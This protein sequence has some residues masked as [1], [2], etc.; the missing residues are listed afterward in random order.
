VVVSDVVFSDT[1]RAD[2]QQRITRLTRSGCAV[3]WLALD[4]AAPLDGSHP[5]LLDDPADAAATIGRAAARALPRRLMGCLTPA[6]SEAANM[7]TTPD[8]VR[9]FQEAGVPFAPGKAANAGGVATSGLEMAQNAGRESWTFEKAEAELTRIMK[10][11]H[12]DCHETAERYG[13]PG[14]YVM[15]ANIAAFERISDAILAQGL[16]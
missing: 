15:G 1:E 2:G 16:I 13:A 7:P 11:I 4:L 5:V 6:V 8:A 10:T 12:D 9:L 14:D 3:L